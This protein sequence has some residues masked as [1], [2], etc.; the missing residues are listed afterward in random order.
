MKTLSV[1]KLGVE[2]EFHLV[3]LATRSLASRAPDLLQRLPGS[4]FVEELQSCVVEL[5]SGVTADLGDLRDELSRQR[6]LVADHAREIG[7]GV[8]AAGTVPLASPAN[9]W[10]TDNPRYR[11]MAADYAVLAREQLICGVQFHVDMPD[12]DQAIQVAHRIAPHLPILLALSASSPFAADGSDTGYASSRTLVWSRWP[13]TGP[14]PPA[15]SAEEYDRLLDQMISSG[16]ISDPGMAYFDVRPSARVDTLELRVCDSCP[17]L[18]VVEL[19]A[20]LYRALVMRAQEDIAAGVEAPDIPDSLIVAARWRAARF[21][22]EGELADLRDFTSRPAHDV[23]RDLVEEVAPQ[24]KRAGDLEAVRELTGRVLHHGSSASRQRRVL[25][26]RARLVDVVDELI[27][28]TSGERESSIGEAW[29][30]DGGPRDYQ[31]VSLADGAFAH[32]EAVDADGAPRSGMEDVLESI[33]TLGPAELRRRQAKME[34]QEEIEGVTFRV[35]GES[36]PR[37]FPVDVVP[38]LIGPDDWSMLSRGLEQRSVALNLF[39]DDLYT[40]QLCLRDGIVPPEMVDR[41]TGYRRYGRAARH[42]V[43]ANVIGSDVVK[44]GE[45]GWMVLEDNCRVPSGT[46]FAMAA[47]RLTSTFLPEIAAPG[48]LLDPGDVG[49]MFRDTLVAAAPSSIHPGAWAPVDPD[50]VELALVTT[51]R[52]DS[53]WHEHS[54]LARLVGM[55]LVTPEELVVDND[56]LY[57]ISDGSPKRIDVL[58]ARIDEDML[59][60]SKGADGSPLGPGLTTAQALGALTIANAM[61]NGVADDKAVYSKVPDLI[62]YYLSEEPLIAQVP[63]YLCADREQRDHVLANIGD[64]VVKPIDGFGGAGVTIG[65]ECTEAELAARAEDLNNHPER[66]IGQPVVGLSTHPTFDGAG[67]GPRHVDLRVFVHAREENGAV[68]AR[69]APSP[70]TRVAPEGSMIVNSSRGGGAKDTWVLRD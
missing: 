47:R 28:I 56:V 50:D 16:C 39:L 70:L 13:A 7:L 44:S 40:R 52:Q 3:D 38:R 9:L 29:S 1:P 18:D 33:T 68:V 49:A 27:A 6:R 65:P 57:R 55:A 35:T 62:R 51:G 42:R 20:G 4:A 64:L 2:E 30:D 36:A 17:S 46:A 41:A 48:T 11:T 60:S 10:V 45:D 5:N 24:L 59:M 31:L 67:F 26:R 54:E 21:G 43:R 32:D 14:R 19:I 23:V 12:R 61:G 15:N 8:V 22:M 63:T 66:Y 37:P 53:A 34:R 25:N 58:Y 69:T